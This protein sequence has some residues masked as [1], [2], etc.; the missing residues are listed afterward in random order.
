MHLLRGNAE[1]RV[2]SGPESDIYV[3]ISLRFFGKI[4]YFP[5]PKNFIPIEARFFLGIIRRKNDATAQ[6]TFLHLL[7][8]LKSEERK[9][10]KLHKSVDQ[11]YFRQTLHL[12]KM[13]LLFPPLVFRTSPPLREVSGWLRRFFF[14]ILFLKNPFFSP[15]IS[16]RIIKLFKR[17][18]SE[19]DNQTS[20]TPNIQ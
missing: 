8:V 6:T 7:T 20:S 16:Q 10:E 4:K 12:S 15:T 11:K 13:S 14:R 9:E 2:V 5:T 18:I 3:A 17:Q 1:G 19:K